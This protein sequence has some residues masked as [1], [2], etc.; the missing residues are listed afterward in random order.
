VRLQAVI[1][2]SFNSDSNAFSPENTDETMEG[3]KVY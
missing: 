2:T 1:W 3:M